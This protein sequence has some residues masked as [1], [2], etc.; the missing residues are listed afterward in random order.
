MKVDQWERIYSFELWVFVSLFVVNRVMSTV[1]AV[2]GSLSQK[3]Y[4]YSNHLPKSKVNG[5][6][7]LKAMFSLTL[8][9][10]HR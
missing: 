10:L 3:H 6:S 5:L 7:S 4:Y 9:I 1:V 8:T 2:V